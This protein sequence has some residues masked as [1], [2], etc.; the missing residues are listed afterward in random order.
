M[1]LQ[2]TGPISLDNIQTE[3]GGANP[4]GLNEYYGVS[5]NIPA[6]GLIS[7]GNFYGAASGP[8]A[9]TG[10]QQINPPSG[11]TWANGLPGF[12]HVTEETFYVMVQDGTGNWYLALT[13]DY[14]LTYTINTSWVADAIHLN[15]NR[16]VVFL[17]EGGQYI[18]IGANKY[19]GGSYSYRVGRF[20]NRGV[21]AYNVAN[22]VRDVTYG[23]N[24]PPYSI[25][26]Q[27]ETG[28][29]FLTWS[30]MFNWTPPAAVTVIGSNGAYISSG[31]MDAYNNNFAFANGGGDGAIRFYTSS[32]AMVTATQRYSFAG[33]GY[34]QADFKKDGTSNGMW[35]WTSFNTPN[36]L[37]CQKFTN[38]GA[39]TVGG[40]VNLGE[41]TY[42][43]GSNFG[44]RPLYDRL[45]GAYYIYNTGTFGVQMY[46]NFYYSPTEAYN[47]NNDQVL[48]ASIPT[49]GKDRVYISK[50]NGPARPVVI[51]GDTNT[52]Y[53]II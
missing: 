38:W 31:T 39:T 29:N 37:Y 12:V 45:G 46:N 41:T 27:T 24:P 30:S 7:I 3:F 53:R 50:L 22:G 10:L 42:N 11:Y 49:S 44:Q 6:S 36:T 13:T 25:R 5:A 47:L 20:N 28:T 26:K 32:N 2:T 9:P 21:S 1:A 18:Q 19:I 8:S 4:I 15:I 16:N 40:V 34:G 52:A 48:L 43:V 14:G 17:S 33:T 23:T 35:T 51:N